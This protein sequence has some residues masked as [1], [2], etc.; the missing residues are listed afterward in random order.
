[1]SKAEQPKELPPPQGLQ[2]SSKTP[3]ANSPI[4]SLVIQK[5]SILLSLRNI[6]K[7]VSFFRTPRKLLL[8]PHFVSNVPKTPQNYGK[9]EKLIVIVPNPKGI[10]FSKW[11]S[12]AAIATL[13]L[14]YLLPSSQICMP[15]PLPPTA[16]RKRSSQS[17]EFR[18]LLIIWSSAQL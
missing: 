1:M 3:P 14:E 9:H 5:S 15:R 16:P 11:G 17:H 12:R 10:Q 4:S 13:H 2:S 7:I 18:S 6:K 8:D